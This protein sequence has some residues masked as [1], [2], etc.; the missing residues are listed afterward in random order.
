MVSPV[1]FL[2]GAQLA[3]DA[4]DGARNLVASDGAGLNP[5]KAV[6]RAAVRAWCRGSNLPTLLPVNRSVIDYVCDPLYNEPGNAPA[7]GASQTT[8]TVQRPAIGAGCTPAGILPQVV[9]V[10]GV[11]SDL[12]IRLWV[13]NPSGLCPNAA[14]RGY[15][16]L[17]GSSVIGSFQEFE[18]YTAAPTIGSV[19]YDDQPPV[20]A[21]P[22]T[23]GDSIDTPIGPVTVDIDPWG[24]TINLPDGTPV[25]IPIDP[26]Q[27]VTPDD[28]PIPD[29]PITPDPPQ[30]PDLGGDVDFGAPPD[31]YEWVGAYYSMQPPDYVGRWAGQPGTPVL[32]EAVALLRLRHD[33][34]KLGQAVTLYSAEGM[35]LRGGDRVPV[36]GVRVWEKYPVNLQVQGVAAK[37]DESNTETP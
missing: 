21:D 11:Y 18:Q 3:S 27:P 9:T 32:Y 19:E 14:G 1:G 26:T 8:V 22:Y 15:Q 33:D 31:G 16:L 24:P 13:T 37:I 34:S 35:V 12:S 4:I 20:I 29:D 2:E 36:T 30:S 25:P 10:D 7:G 6:A 28:P 17:S 23:P 5:V